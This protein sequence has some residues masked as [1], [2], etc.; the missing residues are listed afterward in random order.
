MCNT[1]PVTGGNVNI[2]AVQL[3]TRGIANRMNDNVDI[4]PVLAQFL[5]DIFNLFI[6]GDIA[7]EGQLAAPLLGEF[8]N[9]WLELFVLV[10]ESQF[11][12]FAGKCLGDAVSNGQF[13]GYA[14]DQCFFATEDSHGSFSLCS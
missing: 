6:A 10:G 13:A 3:V 11:S 9:T 5:E 4:V 2:V 14:N 8:L 12:A 7:G 1:E